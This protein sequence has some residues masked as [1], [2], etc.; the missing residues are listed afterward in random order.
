VRD[1][2]QHVSDIVHIAMHTSRNPPSWPA[3]NTQLGRPSQESSCP[4]MTP[5]DTFVELFHDVGTLIPTY[6]S[7]DRM[8]IAMK[9]Q[10]AI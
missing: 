2:N 10:L 4:P 1:A 3:N 6:E 9:E 7:K 8:G 5:I